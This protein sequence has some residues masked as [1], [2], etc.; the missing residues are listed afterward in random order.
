MT[1]L[2]DVPCSISGQVEEMNVTTAVSPFKPISP[3]GVAGGI[4]GGEFQSIVAHH[5]K[6][7][8]QCGKAWNP[9]LNIIFPIISAI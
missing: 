4:G 8:V 7:V 5:G 3:D 9:N 6:A 1:Y 2:N